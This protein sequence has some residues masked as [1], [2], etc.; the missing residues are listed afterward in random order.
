MR[1]DQLYLNKFCPNNWGIYK[2]TWAK[3][4]KDGTR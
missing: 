1:L 3:V 2:K 4:N